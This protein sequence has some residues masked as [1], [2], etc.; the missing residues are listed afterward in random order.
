MITDLDT[1]QQR[2]LAIGILV[3]AVLLL[4]SVTVGPVWYANASRQALLDETQER[5]TR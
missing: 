4:L 1:K 5:L 2:Q 3:L